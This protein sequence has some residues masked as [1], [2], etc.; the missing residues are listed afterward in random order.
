VIPL[1]FGSAFFFTTNILENQK[2]ISSMNQEI[3]RLTRLQEK[4]KELLTNISNY[5]KRIQNFDETMNILNE[6]TSGTKVYSNVL[7]NVS[8]FIGKRRNFWITQLQN[9]S[10][11]ESNLTMS[12]YSLSRTVLTEFVDENNFSLLNNIIY[13]PLR[14]YR[15]FE[16]NLELNFGPK[17]KEEKV[18]ESKNN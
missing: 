3:E 8:D 17:E 10:K 5:E 9:S 16:F 12:G 1:I 13:E 11:E 18:K 7:G 14:D 15:A 2:T 6:A 4:N